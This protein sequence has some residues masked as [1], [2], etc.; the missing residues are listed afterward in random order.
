[1]RVRM[2]KGLSCVLLLALLLSALPGMQLAAWADDIEE[3]EPEMP[4]IVAA[5]EDEAGGE[6]AQQDVESEPDVVPGGETIPNAGE[7][8]EVLD[9]NCL[10]PVEIGGPT[11]PAD[12]PDAEAEEPAPETVAEN[13]DADGTEPAQ[14]VPTPGPVIIP[15]M[16]NGGGTGVRLYAEATLDENFGLNLYISLPADADPAQYRVRTVCEAQMSERTIDRSLSADDKADGLY[17]IPDIVEARIYQL[18]APVEIT[19]FRGETQLRHEVYSVRDYLEELAA[20]SEDHTKFCV[21]ALCFGGAAQRWLDGRSFTLGEVEHEYE[22]FADDLADKNLTVPEPPY[23]LPDPSRP[24]RDTVY[25]GSI[26]NLGNLA[27]RFQTGVETAL[28]FYF[29]YPQKPAALT[30]SADGYTFSEAEAQASSFWYVD[31]TGIKATELANDFV[32]N[33]ALNNQKISIIYSPFY[34]AA[35]HWNSSD[36]KLAEL[37]RMLVACGNEAAALAAVVRSEQYEA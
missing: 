35:Q 36:A 16:V 4:E 33:A 7:R 8:G 26:T 31:L 23:P 5:P 14:S 3:I 22:V 27:A 28:R 25:T 30:F 9:E 2:K 24:L 1:M 20:V 18:T 34:Y 19:V 17:V 6:T 15:G 11:E 29:S 32:V 13:E 10:P 37:C 21:A 12:D